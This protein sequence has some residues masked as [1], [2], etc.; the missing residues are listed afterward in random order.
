MYP[1]VLIGSPVFKREWILPTWFRAIEEQKYPLDRIGFVFELGPNDPE[2]EQILFDWHSKHPEVFAFD[3]HTEENVRHE[4][5]PEGTRPWTYSKYE[6]MATLRNNLLSRVRCLEPDRYFSLDSDIILSNKTTIAQLVHHTETLDAVNILCH[7]HPKTERFPS[8]MSW[9][10]QPGRKAKRLHD[11]YPI[12]TLFQADIIMAAKMMSKPVYMNTSYYAHRQGEDL[13][14]SGDCA[15]QGFK[16]WCA[17]DIKADHIMHR[18][19]LE[20]FKGLN[21]EYCA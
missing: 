6:K 18:W 8:V 4:M 5:H 20:E 3:V 21:Q 16:L 13:G 10:E 19:M 14:W 11:R 9:V 15:R 7:M 17:S 1:K 2:T 12:G